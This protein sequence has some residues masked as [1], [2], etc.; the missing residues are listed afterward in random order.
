MYTI[1]VGQNPTGAVS[2]SRLQYDRS[3]DFTMQTMWGARKKEIYDICVE[4][5]VIIVED[6]PYYFLQV[7]PYTPKPNRPTKP[8]GS[9]DDD[10][11]EHIASLAPSFL[12]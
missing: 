10:P 6:D 3:A 1:P 2:E 9:E 7:G 8:E 5:D 4:F 11:A 12:K